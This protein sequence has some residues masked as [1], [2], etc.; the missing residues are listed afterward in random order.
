VPGP[1][2]RGTDAEEREARLRFPRAIWIG[3][4]HLTLVE[5]LAVVV[6]LAVFGDLG[7]DGPLWDGRLELILHLIGGAALTAGLIALLRGA[8]Y[9]RSG[10]EIP[11]LAFLVALGLATLLGQNHE[12]GR[13]HV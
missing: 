9:P 6:G 11:I 4:A 5:L 8:R 12:I 7:W 2:G 10:L 13:A 1:E 3:R